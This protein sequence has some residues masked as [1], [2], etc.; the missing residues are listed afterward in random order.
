MELI[1]ILHLYVSPAH[2][3]FGHYGR[4]ADE[5]PIIECDEISCVEGRGIKSD[6]FFDYK[7]D[8]KGQIS[9]FADEVHQAL[10]MEFGVT[11]V[12]AAVFRRNVL[13]RG[14]DLNSLI[15][16]EF[17]LQGVR[18]LGTGECKPCY[19]MNT[20]FHSGAEASLQGRGG[21][22]AKILTSGR[23]C[24]TARMT[25]ASKLAFLREGAN[26]GVA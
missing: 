14:I 24:S 19:W 8:Y 9:F 25:R 4:E 22:R 15:G 16:R 11:P 1:E 26:A 13:T 10:H 2:N 20:A 3:Y 5:H 7:P 21:L 17:S 18:F 6:R 23:L 12:S